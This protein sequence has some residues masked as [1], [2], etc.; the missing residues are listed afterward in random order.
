MKPSPIEAEVFV[1]SF[2]PGVEK[3]ADELKS[4]SGE[5]T[6][7]TR[8]IKL[9]LGETSA[10]YG[11]RPI[12]SDGSAM[13]EFMLDLVWWNGLGG[14]AELACES[15]F[16]NLRDPKGNAGRVAEDFDKLL[17][18]KA[19]F[20]LMIFDSYG[21]RKD[22]SNP[23]R[24]A[25]LT[26]LNRYLREYGDHRIGEQYVLV[27]M[28]SGKSAAWLCLILQEGEDTTL[29]FKPIPVD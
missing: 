5:Y 23:N 16:G 28:C 1:R 6:R 24:D 9:W 3:R 26:E 18:F 17:N 2:I 20:K 14:R 13:R 25:V 7:W 15:E 10:V 19:P 11:C 27:D 22:G 12:Y 29:T 21:A 8:A 4:I